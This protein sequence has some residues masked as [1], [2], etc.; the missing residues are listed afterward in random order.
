MN[1]W[2]ALQCVAISAVLIAPLAR[3]EEP[4]PQD[5]ASPDDSAAAPERKPITSTSG[6][7]PSETLQERMARFKREKGAGSDR[8][9]DGFATQ[10]ERDA[11]AMREA[12]VG[13]SV[14]GVRSKE[15]REQ[16]TENTEDR[17]AEEEMLEDRLS[18]LSEMWGASGC[19]LNVEPNWNA[20]EEFI[21]HRK[22]TRG[23]FLYENANKLQLTVPVPKARPRAYTSQAF[24][25]VAQTQVR[26]TEDGKFLAEVTSIR[27]FALISRVESYLP[28]E[29][30][31][32]HLAA[33][34]GHEQLHFD[35]AE[36]LA[37][38]INSL[39]EKLRARYRGVGRS[40]EEAAGELQL[41]WGQ[42]MKLVQEDFRRLETAYD[43]DTKHGG[44]PEKQT[45][46]LWRVDDGFAAFARGVKLA[47]L[48]GLE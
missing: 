8:P 36:A 45:E 34:L 38:H 31:D 25:C 41:E 20:Q 4:L 21:K 39:G 17:V 10:A 23:D 47:S 5:A 35:I 15:E 3:G 32:S 7:A 27:Y 24:G 44:L 16:W 40:P 26:P 48:K 33:V 28:E 12:A 6:S 14:D 29:T 46:W 18:Q 19:F 9:F 37:R 42:L 30:P 43:R 13:G 2:R 11:Q 1:A 22:L